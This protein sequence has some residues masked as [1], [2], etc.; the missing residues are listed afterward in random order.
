[1]ID[2]KPCPKCGRRPSLGYVCGEFF[3]VGQVRGCGVCDTFG[4]M[5]ACRDQDAEGC[6][7]R[8]DNG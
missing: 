4:E 1:M 8:A 7:R 6:N 2:L 5:H 3:I